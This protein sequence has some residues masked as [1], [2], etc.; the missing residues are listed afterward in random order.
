[1]AVVYDEST[2]E[3]YMH[4]AA[5][6]SPGHP[7]L[8]DRFL[9]DAFEVDLDLLSDGRTAVVAG[10]LQHIEEAG[11][12]S[13]DSVAVLPPYKV[14]QEDQDRMRDIA[15]RL[16]LR[17]GVVGL[18]NVQFAL[19]DGRIYV[20]EVNP[21]ASRTVPF[22]AKAVGVPLVKI[23]HGRDGWED[24]ARSWASPRSRRC[25]ASS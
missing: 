3:R 1:M 13:G 6:V 21:R 17:L 16:A 8:I 5:E 19:K 10:I 7:V 23:A 9:E 4:E 2:L 15:K 24:P 25:R 22:I 12:H 20:L 18:M 11:I 14:S